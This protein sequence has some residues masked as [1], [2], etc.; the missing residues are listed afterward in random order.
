LREGDVAEIRFDGFGRPLRNPVHEEV[1]SLKLVQ[2]RSLAE[3]Q[4]GER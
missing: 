3:N 4:Q 2:V 1:K